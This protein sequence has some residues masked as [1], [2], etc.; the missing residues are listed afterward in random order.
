M[1]GKKSGYA[2]QRLS[3]RRTF[4]TMIKAV[5]V[6]LMCWL[7]GQFNLPYTLVF[8]GI[9]AFVAGYM[10]IRRSITP[11]K[12]I[13]ALALLSVLIL[14]EAIHWLLHPYLPNLASRQLVLAGIALA[15][16]PLYYIIEKWIRKKL[17]EKNKKL[18][19]AAAK[20]RIASN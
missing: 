10:L 5:I 12:I 16:T 1:S 17:I 15:L 14:F 13:G 20:K 2:S 11:I 3:G 8:L 4:V 7:A 9:L 6:V 19:L 18:R